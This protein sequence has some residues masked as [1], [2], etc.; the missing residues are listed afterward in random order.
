MAMDPKFRRNLETLKRAK[1]FQDEMDKAGFGRPA[2]PSVISQYPHCDQKILHAP[3]ECDY[4]DMHPDWQELREIWGINFTGHSEE[5][6]TKCPAERERNID[7]INKWGGNLTTVHLIQE[8]PD[9][10]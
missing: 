6:K 5:G 1:K 3:G 2:I 7:T 4:C 9:A 10:V 8:E